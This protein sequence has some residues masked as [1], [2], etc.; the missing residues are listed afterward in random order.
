MKEEG[1]WCNAGSSC[2]IQI[3]PVLD[4]SSEK[5]TLTAKVHHCCSY[6]RKI[7]PDAAGHSCYIHWCLSGI[8]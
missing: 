8:Q 5:D 2:S 6:R 1:F 4:L 3:C 7:Y